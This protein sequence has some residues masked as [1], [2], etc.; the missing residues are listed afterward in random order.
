MMTDQS[1]QS[2]VITGEDDSVQKLVVWGTRQVDIRAMLW[3]STRTNPGAQVDLFS[4][5]NL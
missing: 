4:D 5:W 3:I 1:S 2:R